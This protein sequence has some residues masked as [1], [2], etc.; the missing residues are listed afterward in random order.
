[1]QATIN[2]IITALLLQIWYL[3]AS[4]LV[5]PSTGRLQETHYPLRIIASGASVPTDWAYP[6][7]NFTNTRRLT[8]P[9]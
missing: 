5:D 4:L 6:P 7:H 3:A 9:D 8:S 2:I 1:M